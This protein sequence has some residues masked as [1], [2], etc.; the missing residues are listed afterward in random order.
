MYVDQTNKRNDIQNTKES[1]LSETFTAGGPK[2]NLVNKEK[3]A[4]A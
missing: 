2:V 1:P 4:D 3:E